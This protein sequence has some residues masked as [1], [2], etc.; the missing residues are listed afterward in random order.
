MAPWGCVALCQCSCC[1]SKSSQHKRCFNWKPTALKKCPKSFHFAQ[2]SNFTCTGLHW[3]CYFWRSFRIWPLSLNE[4]WHPAMYVARLLFCFGN[5]SSGRVKLACQSSLGLSFSAKLT[6]GSRLGWAGLK[7]WQTGLFVWGDNAVKMLWSDSWK[8]KY[9]EKG[10]HTEGIRFHLEEHLFPPCSEQVGNE[11]N[12]QRLEWNRRW[13]MSLMNGGY[14][15][16]ARGDGSRLNWCKCGYSSFSYRKDGRSE[17]SA[18]PHPHTWVYSDTRRCWTG[19]EAI[20]L[21]VDTRR[22]RHF[23]PSHMPWAPTV[24][25]HTHTW[26]DWPSVGCLQILLFIL[27]I[28]LKC[29]RSSVI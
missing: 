15:Y 2:I 19:V 21:Q 25:L 9:L 26:W 1:V 24:G 17:Y 3:Q 23:Q 14:R 8:E 5:I 7:L 11:A 22:L 16:V 13:E 18:P 12:W 29:I 27:L 10:R 4:K 28:F 6:S 20:I